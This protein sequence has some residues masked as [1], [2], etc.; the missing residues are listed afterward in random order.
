M[1]APPSIHATE[2]QLRERCCLLFEWF[3]EEE[4]DMVDITTE[5]MLYLDGEIDVELYPSPRESRIRSSEL[6]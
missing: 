5:G 6:V 2:R 4:L 1:A 3:G